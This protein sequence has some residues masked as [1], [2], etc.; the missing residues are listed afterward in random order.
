[1]A[2][3]ERRT[4]MPGKVMRVC[5]SAIVAI[6][7]WLSLAW[8]LGGQA[9]SSVD[10][11]LRPFGLDDFTGAIMLVAEVASSVVLLFACYQLISNRLNVAFWRVLAAAYGVCLFAVVM[12]KSVGVREVNFN[13]VDLLPQ[14]IEYPASV[15]VN[16]LLFVPVG[17]LVGWRFRRPLIAL[18]L[19]LLGIAAVEV[20]QYALGLGIADVVDVVVDFAGL[21]LGYLVAD[22]L[23]LAGVGLNG[24]GAHVRFAR[25]APREGAVRA[26][27][28]RLGL[29][30]AAA[31]AVAVTIG[32]ALA[33]YDYDP[34]AFMDGMTQE[35]FEAAMMDGEI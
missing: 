16:F 20:V 27:G 26:A 22:V 4:S 13:M 33:H 8:V 1:M 23:R 9:F 18:P 17:A 19:G 35:E 7:W 34:Y 24:D 12:L 2:A 29:A 28:M 15:V 32:V 21:C 11:L 14:L 5:V 10:M 6:A 31:V 25:S 30:A 3:D